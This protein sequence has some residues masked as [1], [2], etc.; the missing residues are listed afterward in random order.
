M[1][2]P[3]TS[4]L[5]QVGNFFNETGATLGQGRLL[6]FTCS[7]QGTLG[8]IMGQVSGLLAAANSLNS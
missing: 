1:Y 3:N 5:V 7:S 2:D 8:A 4:S 6:D